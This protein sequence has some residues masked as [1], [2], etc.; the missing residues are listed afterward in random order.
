[1][2]FF[3][4]IAVVIT[5]A[6][7]CWDGI[8]KVNGNGPGEVFFLGSNLSPAFYYLYNFVKLFNLSKL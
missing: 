5:I 1:M 6:T 3:K 4:M 7:F 2:F 8:V